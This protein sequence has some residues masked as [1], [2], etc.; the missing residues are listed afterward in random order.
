MSDSDMLLVT[1][2]VIAALI[3]LCIALAGRLAELRYQMAHRDDF[4][5]PP[6]LCSDCGTGL[7]YSEHET[8]TDCR[9]VRFLRD[10]E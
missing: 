6:M 1:W 8:C 3:V 5:S 9:H 7:R 10:C 4:D 2:L